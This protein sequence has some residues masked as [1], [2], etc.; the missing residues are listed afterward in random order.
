[1]DDPAA[2]VT[3]SVVR[4]GGGEGAVTL[5]W[6]L[7][8]RAAGDLSPLNGTL[9][10]TEVGEERRHPPVSSLKG[11]FVKYSLFFFS[12]AQTLKSFTIEALTDAALEGEERFNVRLFPAQPDAVVDPLNGQFEAPFQF[13]NGES[14][15]LVCP[16]LL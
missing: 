13:R 1:M 5:L 14:N 11:S 8:E 4:S 10:F 7:E 15:G 6:Q 12:Q 3:L 16:P 9:V 2:Q